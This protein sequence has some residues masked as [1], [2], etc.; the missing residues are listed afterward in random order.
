MFAQFSDA[1]ETAIIGIFYSEQPSADVPYQ[2]QI[3][4]S[5]PRY[6]V[7]WDALLPGTITAGLEP[8]TT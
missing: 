8:P 7:W 3:D 2:A 4:A 1:T 6:K 5:D